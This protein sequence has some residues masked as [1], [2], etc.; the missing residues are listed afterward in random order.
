MQEHVGCP[1]CGVRACVFVSLIITIGDQSHDRGHGYQNIVMIE[2][3]G[4]CFVSAWGSHRGAGN[5][6]V[7]EFAGVPERA[8]F[9]L[10][11]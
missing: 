11:A 6:D 4:G 7:W 1:D 10:R 8:E 3:H 5:R 9:S 2:S